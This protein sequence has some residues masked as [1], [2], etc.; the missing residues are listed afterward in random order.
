MGGYGSG[1]KRSRSS[2]GSYRR[3]DIRNLSR[4]G[5]LDD[6]CVCSVRWSGGGAQPEQVYITAADGELRFTYGK[7]A[8]NRGTGTAEL[9]IRGRRIT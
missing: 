2:E 3:L 8:E 7:Y 4:G 9:C 6:G 5:A 1:R